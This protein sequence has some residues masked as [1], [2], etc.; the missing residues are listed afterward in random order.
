MVSTIAFIAMSYLAGSV[1]SA[2][3]VCRL[4]GYP[5]P[6]T[7]GSGNPGATNVLRVAGR[8]AAAVTLAGDLCK[9]LLPLLLGRALGAADPVLA[10]MGAAA[11]LGHLYPI[12]FAFQGGKGIAT[13]I[14]VLVG[15]CWPAGLGFA[16]VW[17]TLAALFRYSSLAG[18][19][20]ALVSPLIVY[21]VMGSGAILGVVCGMVVLIFWR[22][23]SNIRNL[24]AGTEGKIHGTRGAERSKTR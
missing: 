22:H 5:D 20:A 24:L 1:S 17:L 7:Q 8:T 12:F 19:G 11:F 6:R 9:G 4:G 18:L 14:G 21:T 16:V 13:F 10:A 15:L 3:V 23:R 2:I